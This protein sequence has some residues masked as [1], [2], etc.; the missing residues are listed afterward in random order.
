MR[1]LACS[2]RARRSYRAISSATASAR[3]CAGLAG[4]ASGLSGTAFVAGSFSTCWKRGEQRWQMFGLF[5]VAVP[6]TGPARSTLFPAVSSASA[7]WICRVVSCATGRAGCGAAGH[8]LAPRFGL[9]QQGYEALDIP[10]ANLL[11]EDDD[12]VPGT[13]GKASPGLCRG[14]SGVAVARTGRGR[15]GHLG[16]SQQAEGVARLTGSCPDAA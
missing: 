13:A 1:P 8:L 10:V 15:S 9:Q 6:A 3:S 12:Y 11:F 2:K 5:C 4:Q 14:A 7:A 16:C